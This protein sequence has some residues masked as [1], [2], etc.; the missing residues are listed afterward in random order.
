MQELIDRAT[1]VIEEAGEKYDNLWFGWT[2]GK[3]S[4]LL[5]WLAQQADIDPVRAIFIDTKYHFDETYTFIDE[6]EA[7]WDIELHTEAFPNELSDDEFDDPYIRNQKLKTVPLH[8]AIKRL[9]VDAFATGIRHD[10][11]EARE[12][13]TYFSPREYEEE[14]MEDL[15]HMRVHPILHFEERAVWETIIE[16]DIPIHPLYKE[17][18]RS[19]GSTYDTEVS[20]PG[21]PAWEQDLEEG[22]E[23]DGRGQS[24][25][26]LMSRLRD[27][28]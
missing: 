2:G 13:E 19:I 9:G 3:D 20:E 1:A 22:T 28:R 8:I 12:D 15:R 6:I 18:Y 5:L 26:N 27:Y 14:E 21:V 24:K 23:R 16:N 25:E 4:T 7:E 10:E 11:S 17:G